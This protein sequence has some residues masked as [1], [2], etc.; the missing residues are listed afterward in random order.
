MCSQCFS[1]HLFFMSLSQ[2]NRFYDLEEHLKI[3]IN[4]PTNEMPILSVQSKWKTSLPFHTKE[5]S[6]SFSQHQFKK[7]HSFLDTQAAEQHSTP[8]F[9][10]RCLLPGAAVRQNIN[11][12]TVKTTKKKHFLFWFPSPEAGV[13][14]HLQVG[15]Q[16]SPA[17][18]KD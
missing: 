15:P 14:D 12:L 6:R 18:V 11:F 13:C 2:F 4:P 1:R 7:T 8:R 3:K 5:Q 17:E 9:L 16:Q 10:L